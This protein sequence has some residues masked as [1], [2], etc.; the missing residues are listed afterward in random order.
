MRIPSVKKLRKDLGRSQKEMAEVLG[1]SKKA[2]QSYEQGWRNVPPHIEQLLLLHT[3]LH[4]GPDLKKVLPCWEQNDCKPS[5]C[6]SCPAG[7]LSS[8]G[9]CWLVTGTLCHGERMGTWKA[10]R[11]R[12]LK[13]KI[14]RELLGQSVA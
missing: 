2:V 12:C 13:C 10:K 9:F 4:W 8:A 6:A 14:L 5:V 1:I 11:N 7:S 3:I